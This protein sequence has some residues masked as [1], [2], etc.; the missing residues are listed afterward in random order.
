[1]AEQWFL[2]LDGVKS[3]PYH[4]PEV[5]SLVAE[6]EVLPHHRISTALRD[7]AWITVLDWRLE[8]AKKTIEKTPEVPK[9]EIIAMDEV[10]ENPVETKAVP[11]P[12]FKAPPEWIQEIPITEIPN[13]KPTPSST[14]TSLP[15]TAATKA[16]QA[17]VTVPTAK[18][19]ARETPHPSETATPPKRDPMAEMFDMLQESKQKKEAKNLKSAQQEALN[20][21]PKEIKSSGTLGKTIFIG[22]GIV[23][24]GFLLGQ[25]FQQAAPPPQPTKETSKTEAKASPTATPDA[26]KEVRTEVIDRSTD[27]MTI[28]A[29]VERTPTPIPHRA[30]IRPINA[31]GLGQAPEKKMNDREME[32]LKDLK[33]ELQEL[34]AMKDDLKNNPDG[35]NDPNNPEEPE[36]NPAEYPNQPRN[37]P[38]SNLAPGA[39]N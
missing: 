10:A 3:G 31:P 26:S 18:T 7:A 34:K 23:L 9:I 15:P 6:G 19:I 29:I 5:M 17:S 11:P 35:E 16:T 4:T 39:G 38:N 1:M 32:E 37:A 25:I 13:L 20:S 24:I 14:H 8:Q 2:D 12:I 33:K 27:K 30:E 28:R 22:A 36:S 21:A